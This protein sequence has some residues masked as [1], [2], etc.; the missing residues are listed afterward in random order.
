MAPSIGIEYTKFISM[1]CGYPFLSI[2]AVLKTGCSLEKNAIIYSLTLFPPFLELFTTVIMICVNYVIVNI[3]HLFKIMT[4]MICE[5]MII[6]DYKLV[7]LA[8][9]SYLSIQL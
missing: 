7:N 1:I 4:R 3:Y 9:I 8:K 6:M 2:K 5:F